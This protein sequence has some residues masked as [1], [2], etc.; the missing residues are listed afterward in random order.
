MS[1]QDQLH[2]AVALD[3]AGWHPASW[4]SPTARPRDLL[5]AGYWT[6]VV[7][8]AERGLLDFVTIEDGFAVTDDHHAGES[9]RTDR[10]VGRLDAQL[11]ASRIGPVT[12]W[13]GL[14]PTVVAPLTEPF[15]TSKAVATLDYVSGGRAGVRVRTSA[16][17]AE[18][19]NIG[20]REAPV[21]G[22]GGV[23]PDGPLVEEAFAE[24]G[25]YVEVL[26]RLWD[27][28]EDDAEIR[29]VATGRFVDRNKLHYID[30]EG[31]HFSVRGPSITP[32]PPQ[33]QPLVTLLVHQPSGHRLL[34]RSADIGIITPSDGYDVR[35]TVA[36]IRTATVDAD[37]D[38][39]SL[40]LLADL[41][42]LLDTDARA[43]ADRKDQLDTWYGAEFPSDASIFVG[44]PDE[45]TQLIEVWRAAGVDGIRL[46]P[47]TIPHDLLQIT[48]QL[49]PLLQR[50]GAFRT[51]YAADTLRGH[52]EL[53]RPANRYAIA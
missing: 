12:K 25:D 32:R 15:H 44:T 17:P 22:T 21:L 51:R 29:D 14:I 47:A 46:R 48:E 11:I 9:N 1:E 24:V 45:L 43:A 23:I 42:V 28:W 16:S 33:G 2:L 19:G 40:K 26:R 34:A 31:S 36:S 6:D 38:P 27:S 50:T 13:I 8:E 52:F 20:R 4:R 3:G 18:F 53:P 41:V 10:V 37:R 7:R 49:V 39:E 30:F 5:T 35:S